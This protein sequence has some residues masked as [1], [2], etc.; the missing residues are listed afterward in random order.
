[1]SQPVS[2]RLRE[3]IEITAISDKCARQSLAVL[4]RDE[5]GSSYDWEFTPF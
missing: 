2:E 5:G 3:H 1:M 4:W